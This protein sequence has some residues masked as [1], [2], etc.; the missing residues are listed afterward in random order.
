MTKWVGSDLT[1][2]EGAMRRLIFTIVA[3]V[4]LLLVARLVYA[5]MSQLKFYYY[6]YS[7]SN[8]TL[9][10]TATVQTDSFGY[11]IFNADIPAELD[12]YYAL[13][14]RLYTLSGEGEY[15]TFLYKSWDSPCLQ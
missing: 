6:D 7:I 1:E 13:K 8:W 5:D 11:A 2:K 4:G 10:D 15:E 3:I 14:L 9:L 12:D